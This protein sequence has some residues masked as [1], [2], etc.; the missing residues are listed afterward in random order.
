MVH[1]DTRSCARWEPLLPEYVDAC[2]AGLSAQR[3]YPGL[4]RHLS[5]CESCAILVAETVAAMRWREAEEPFNRH[6]L[7]LPALPFRRDSAREDC[8]A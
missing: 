7:T 1:A 5:R 6:A 2:L 3:A 8:C 4:L